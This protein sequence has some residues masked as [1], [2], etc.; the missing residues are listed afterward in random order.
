METHPLDLAEL[1]RESLNFLRPRLKNVELDTA[2]LAHP[3]PILGDK[4]QLEQIIINLL[5]NGWKA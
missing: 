5:L 4:S 2:G 1:A 3:L